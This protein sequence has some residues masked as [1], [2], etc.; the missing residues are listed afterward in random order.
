MAYPAIA[1]VNLTLL[2]TVVSQAN[3]GTPLFLTVHKAYNERVRSYQNV[4]DV[5]QDIGVGTPAH[6]AAQSYFG[7]SPK[8]ATFKVGRIAANAIFG[9]ENVEVGATY[10]VG[11][12]VNGNV[13]L[14]ITYV[15]ITD[16]TAEDVVDALVT[17]VN[18]AYED[19]LTAS[20]IGTGGASQ[21]SIVPDSS[22]F[23]YVIG[24]LEN[25][26]PT[27]TTTESVVQAR[28]SASDEDS[29]FAF[30]TSEY[31]T[32]SEIVS[33][34]SDTQATE[35]LFAFSSFD[36]LVL[37]PL[38]TSSTDTPAVIHNLGND[39]TF[40]VFGDNL[41]SEYPEL[42]VIGRFSTYEPG[43]V[44]WYAKV[45]AGA[46]ISRNPLTGK[47]LTST[48][49]DYVRARDGN[50]FVSEGGI[51][52]FKDGITIT[53]QTIDNSRF[54][55]FLSA[56]LREG[57]TNWRINKLKVP[58]TQ[59]CIDSAQSVVDAILQ[60]YVSTPDRVHAIQRYTLLFPR[61]NRVSRANLVNGLLEA[62]GTIYLAGSILNVIFDGV[63]TFDADF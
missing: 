50:A 45:I 33:L 42:G 47:A 51:V 9:L 4:E 37:T 23:N 46:G 6:L 29:D 62:S 38:L 2:T 27:F 40:W 59:A 44:D 26:F 48:E 43:T 28:Q 58:Y 20:R 57:I 30:V 1:T 24:D 61:R 22:E 55:D 60:N 13:T 54:R 10:T 16:D 21:L 17:Q 41:A 53:K 7:Q 63:I 11:L 34:S 12:A 32:Q 5:A 8:P 36:P 19:Q 35:R 3:F 25:L 31:K 49:Q 39:R 18:I 15:A 56:R 14:P 52:I